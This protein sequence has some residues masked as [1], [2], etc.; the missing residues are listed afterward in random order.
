VSD[1][2]P[3]RAVDQLPDR[4]P[5]RHVRPDA[6]PK[7]GQVRP[8]LEQEGI[9]PDNAGALL[10]AILRR[11]WTAWLVAFPGKPPRFTAFILEPRLG[12]VW[13]EGRGATPA[14][15]L[16]AV[17]VLCLDEPPWERRP[18]DDALPDLANPG[19]T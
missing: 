13:A 7:P 3:W 10:S 15:A 1:F 11:D 16:G 2:A 8:R 19:V 5:I 9:D 6:L 12:A 4:A 18:E 17:T 14:E